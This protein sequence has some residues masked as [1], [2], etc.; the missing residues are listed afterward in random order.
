MSQ[1]SLRRQ[2]GIFW[3]RLSSGGGLTNRVNVTM[4]AKLTIYSAS[5]SP[6]E[7]SAYNARRNWQQLAVVHG[8]IMHQGNHSQCRTTVTPVM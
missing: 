1:L 2:I 4:V 8:Q 7:H 5:H 3:G 6:S